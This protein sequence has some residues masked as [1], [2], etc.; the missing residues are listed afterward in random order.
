MIDKISYRGPDN[1]ETKTGENFSSG[2]SRLAIYGDKKARGIYDSNNITVML[3]GEIYNVSEV[4]NILESAGFRFNTN[5][6][7]EVITNAY[8]YWGINF[9]KHIKGMFAI[10]ITDEN[11]N[12]KI[13]V[14]DR[15]GIKPMYYAKSNN[16][17][18]FAS[19]IKSIKEEIKTTPDK[20]ALEESNIFGYIS[21]TDRTLYNEIKQVNPGE[22][23]VIDKELNITKHN[24]WNKQKA[25]YSDSKDSYAE[26]EKELKDKILKSFDKVFSHGE[27]KKGIYLS[28]GLDS[29]I[30]AYA[31]KK[32]GYDFPAFTMADSEDSEDLKYAKKVAKELGLKHYI[33]IPKKE[34]IKR[35]EKDLAYHY[36]GSITGGVFDI[37]GLMA[38]HLLTEF[39]S[40][41]V[42]VVMSGDGADELFGGYKWTYTHPLGFSD[43]IRSNYDKYGKSDHVKYLI[44]DLFPAKEDELQYRKNVLDFLI[45]GGLSNYH[46]QSV[47]RSSGA[48]GIE[49]RPIFLN[50]DL[51]KYALDIPIDYKANNTM[52]KRILKDAFREDFEKI[53][54]G[55]VID[56]EKI[57]LP[58]SIDIIYKKVAAKQG[59]QVKLNPARNLTQILSE[60]DNKTDKATSTKRLT[61]IEEFNAPTHKAS[62]KKRQ[63][64]K[65]SLSKT[66]EQKQEKEFPN[67]VYYRNHK[68]RKE[69][70]MP[71]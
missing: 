51:V 49:V 41:H 43:R 24:Y 16:T 28:G 8:K 34:D 50:D 3:N 40:K 12:K 60:A 10:S 69:L 6:E 67:P 39:I 11:K 26:T 52:T 13:L 32:L 21:D 14:R 31:A 23:I 62:Y 64:T 65:T 68:L 54:L 2:F 22:T 61:T 25:R 38:F 7:T 1:T 30:I 18:L 29:T 57:G 20:I 66:M 48:Y 35:L 70:H 27:G 15:I 59:T 55:E 37:K 63:P 56:R 5:L 45:N 42:K 36:E 71:L 9:P 33:Y 46:L 58:S 53:D 44:N 47:D 4:R 19:E 17:V